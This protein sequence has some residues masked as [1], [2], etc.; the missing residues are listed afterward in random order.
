MMELKRGGITSGGPEDFLLQAYASQLARCYKIP[1]SIG[2]FCAS[3]KTNDWQAVTK[4]HGFGKGREILNNK[5]E[6]GKADMEISE[7]IA[8]YENEAI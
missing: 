6:F 7:I 8:S 4:D 3:S 5:K 1:S 2:T